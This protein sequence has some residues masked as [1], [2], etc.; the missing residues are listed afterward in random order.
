MPEIKGF[1]VYLRCAPAVERGIVVQNIAQ[2]HSHMRTAHYQEHFC[3]RKGC[4]PVFLEDGQ[5]SGCA[6]DDIGY[7]IYAD[8]QPF[9][10][11]QYLYEVAEKLIPVIK[12]GLE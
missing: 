12:P 4:I 9:I 7:F 1:Q 11:R 10:R 5:E 2:H 6:F 8:N 3:L